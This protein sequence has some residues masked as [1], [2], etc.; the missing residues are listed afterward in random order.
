MSADIGDIG[1]IVAISAE[2]PSD[3][4]DLAHPCRAIYVESTGAVAF[5]DWSNNSVTL[6]GLAGGVWHP[7][8]AKRILATGT[9]AST[10][11]V[12]R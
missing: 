12:G 4:V 9:D 8:A 10:V 1:S 7:I 6:P 11:Y 5:I 3:T 2:T